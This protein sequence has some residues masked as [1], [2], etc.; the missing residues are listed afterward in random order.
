MKPFA[1]RLARIEPFHVMD[2][3]ARARAMEAQGRSIIHMEIGE[4]DFPTAPGIVQ[5]GIAALQ[6]GHTHYTP[7]LGLPALR[8]AIAASYPADVRP[9]PARVV[10]TPG[11]SGALQL[12]F[13]ALVN[14]GDQVLMADPGYPCNRHFVRLFEG[15][16]VSV[17]VDDATTY[18][19]NADLIR[20]HWTARTVAVLL[21]SPSNPTGTLIETGEM[22]EIVRTVEQLGGV[23]IVDE[24]YHGLVYANEA[25][26]AIAHSPE[27]FVVN[28][29]S[30][31]Y[32]MTGW[33]LGWLVAPP[34][35]IPAIDKLA[36][37]IFLASST[38]AQHAALAAFTPAVQEVLAQRRDIFRERR[39]YLLP[40]LRELGF[41]VP[42]VPQG[43]FYLYADASRFT[44]DS[45][46]FALDLLERIGVAITP[47]LD[48]GSYRAA[49][50][51]RFSYA[52]TLE[53]LHEGV[54]R[55]RKYLGRI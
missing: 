36:Q 23:L 2:I 52:T 51:V 20:R 4:P 9:D 29:F 26:T 12:I 17:P 37:N 8:A 15:E 24:I 43:A 18:Q 13:A 21:A 46:A 10:V 49:Q 53:N 39:D 28:S 30:K 6:A 5:A 44:D 14:P 41:R 54:S 48:F 38:V 42:V 31:Y 19:L 34:A 3:L 27:V 47:G 7:S 32:G 50:H 16:P 55:L 33:R 25:V 1:G 40:A 11:A 22:A 45:Q 35:Y